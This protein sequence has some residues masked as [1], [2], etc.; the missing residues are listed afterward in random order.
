LVGY[1]LA[2]A[3]R[4][5]KPVEVEA[6]Q[7]AS[8][9]PAPLGLADVLG[10][11]RAVETLQSAMR[12]ERVHHAWVFHGPAGVGKF[13]TALAFAAAL[14]D[15]TTAPDLTGR[16]APDPDS[17]VQ[18]LLR[19]GAHPDLHV[20]VKELARFSDDRAT[21]ERKLISIPLEVVR[22]HLIDPA[23]LASTM[24][25]GAAAKVFVVD[26]AHL[27]NTPTQNALLKTLEEPPDR[28]VIILVTDSE[29]RLLP[30]IR[31]RS[32]RVAFGTLDN[33]SMREWLK[34]A[35]LGID[36]E[37]TDWLLGYAGGSPGALVRALDAGLEEWHERL[38]PL[39]ARAAKGTYAPDLGPAIAELI[40]E[41][42]TAAAEADK[43]VSKDAAK[44]AAAADMFRLIARQLRERLRHEP[45]AALAEIEALHEAERA[46]N[47][48]VQLPFVAEQLSERLAACGAM[49]NGQ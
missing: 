12:S 42:A 41:R 8:L 37:R 21:R 43:G 46:L 15:P 47:A 19:S 36:P 30:T 28:T 34:G 29:E 38:A 11:E 23:Y 6:S 26:E 39:L 9:H 20:V 40:D 44:K 13:T 45:G 10:Q 3:K 33:G 32:Q 48:A 2:M 1:A 25:G 16:L 7:G 27:L 14:L 35:E 5:K 22:G 4:A 31:S 24:P 18:G 17:R 49:G